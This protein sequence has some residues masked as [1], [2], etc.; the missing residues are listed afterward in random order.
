MLSNNPDR[1]KTLLGLITIEPPPTVPRITGTPVE[2]QFILNRYLMLN[3]SSS[4]RFMK[5]FRQLKRYML[6]S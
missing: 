5:T 1:Q 3:M 2:L 4:N 6:P